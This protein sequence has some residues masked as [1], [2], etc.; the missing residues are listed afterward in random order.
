MPF[1][2][3]GRKIPGFRFV[4]TRE[5]VVDDLD[6]LFVVKFLVSGL[7]ILMVRLMERVS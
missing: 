7:L 6:D 2:G 4:L 1:R 3:L 5:I